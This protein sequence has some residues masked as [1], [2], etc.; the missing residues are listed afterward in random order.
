MKPG[1]DVI[2][3]MTGPAT[4]NMSFERMKQFVDLAKEMAWS[5]IEFDNALALAVANLW[6]NRLV[7]DAGLS[8]NKRLTKSNVRL[9]KDASLLASGL[10]GPATLH[11]TV[12]LRGTRYTCSGM[13]YGGRYSRFRNSSA[14]A[15]FTNRSVWGSKCT[16][17][18]S[19]AEILARWHTV[20]DL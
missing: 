5:W 16:L 3:W 20:A 14:S 7:G 1:V 11:G 17:R 18:P 15:S 2:P 13:M 6:R 9:D 19:W 12:F 10:L 4:N 8:E